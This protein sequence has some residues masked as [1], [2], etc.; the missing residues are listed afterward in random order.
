MDEAVE[1]PELKLQARADLVLCRHFAQG[2]DDVRAMLDAALM[3]VRQVQYE[4]VLKIELVSQHL[5]SP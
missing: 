5:P 4:E 1:L 2:A 3:I